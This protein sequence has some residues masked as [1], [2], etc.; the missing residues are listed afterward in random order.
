MAADYPG[1]EQLIPHR[2]PASLLTAVEEIAGDRAMCRARIPATHPFVSGGR[3]PAFVGL[4]MGAQAAAAVETLA[5]IESAGDGSPR[6]GYLVGVRDA[7]FHSPE[8]PVERSLLVSVLLA[9]RS[10]TL[11]VYRIAVTLDGEIVVEGS[12]ST[13]LA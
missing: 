9:G 3:A 2:P 5:R 11:N 1:I 10:G 4:E 8:L 7:V 12:I 13:T 6:I